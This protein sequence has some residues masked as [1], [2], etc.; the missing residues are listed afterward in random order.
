VKRSRTL[1]L[2]EI[3][4]VADSVASESGLGLPWKMSSSVSS[5]QCFGDTVEAF[6]AFRFLVAFGALVRV[7]GRSTLATAFLNP[8]PGK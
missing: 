4:G 2:S 8:N 6:L 1:D 5:R 3:V 7:V